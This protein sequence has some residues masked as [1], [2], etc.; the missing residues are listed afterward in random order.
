MTR[1]TWLEHRFR[2]RLFV[3]P[4]A[5][6]ISE[7]T[8]AEPVPEQEDADEQENTGRHTTVK[9]KQHGQYYIQSPDQVHKL[10]DVNR[11]AKRW[12]LIPPEE[13]HA[14]SIEH[15]SLKDSDG[16]KCRWLLHTRRVPVLPTPSGASDS[17]MSQP[18]NAS[19]LPICAGVGDPEA[20]VCA[21]WECVNDVCAKKPIMPLNG[22]TNDNWIGR[23]KVHVREASK[24]TKMLASL[25]RCR[26]VEIGATAVGYFSRRALG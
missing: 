2:L 8:V 10:L 22:L 19:S 3:E 18:V 4:P 6:S 13:L 26:C 21:C 1:S 16:N 23:E 11:Y 25:G 7:D 9:L 17:G 5:G 14:S 15:P 12:P 24:A 20:Y